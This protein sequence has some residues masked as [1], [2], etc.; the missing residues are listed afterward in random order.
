MTGTLDDTLIGADKAWLLTAAGCI[1]SMQVGLAWLEA[2]AVR[3]KNQSS[4]YWKLLINI[5]VTVMTFWLFGY[6]FAY[7]DGEGAF[8]GGA[9]FYAGNKWEETFLNFKG[10]WTHFVF[11]VCIACV[12]PAVTGGVVSE[13]ITFKAGAVH[14]FFMMLIIYPVILCWTWGEGWLY[15]EGYAD[16]TGSGMVHVT[17]AFAGLA[18]LLI[19]GPRYQRW[20]T[21]K[22]VFA[23]VQNKPAE[24]TQEN[25]GAQFGTPTKKN[26]IPAVALQANTSPKVNYVVSNASASEKSETS[27]DPSAFTQENISKMRKHVIEESYDAFEVSDLSLVGMGGLFLWFGF[28][29]FNAGSS[30]FIQNETYYRAAE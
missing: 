20:N 9:R 11:Q 3:R 1:F 4:I 7:G 2:G 6:A 24:K 16:F 21:H 14:T 30:L 28:Q 29:F 5:M 23:K 10:Q 18:C 22:D 25:T 13:R 17:A 27:S 8:I 15:K 12:L 26:V 19:V